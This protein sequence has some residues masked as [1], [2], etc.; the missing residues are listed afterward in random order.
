[1]TVSEGSV[2]WQ[3]TAKSIAASHLGK[4]AA[5]V[6]ERRGL[7]FGAPADYDRIWRWSVE[8]PEQFWGDL[9]TFTGVLP[10]VPDDQV[11]TRREMPG[12]VWF[13]GRTIN[14]AEQALKRA[15]TA[16]PAIVAVSETEEPSDISWADLTAQVGAFAATLRRLGV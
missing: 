7:D 9:G 10:G 6:S 15:T 13:P 12:A 2:L 1:M 14:Y 16:H 3:P 8:H 4:F 5:W 11:L